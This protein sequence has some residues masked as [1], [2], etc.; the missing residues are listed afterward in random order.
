MCKILYFKLHRNKKYNKIII[1]NKYT[2]KLRLWL[3][4]LMKLVNKIMKKKTNK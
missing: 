1:F 4:I 3:K 2:N